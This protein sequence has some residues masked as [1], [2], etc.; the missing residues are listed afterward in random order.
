MLLGMA[1]LEIEEIEGPDG[2]LC[3]CGCEEESHS[4]VV[5]GWQ[6]YF[7]AA[8][9]CKEAVARDFLRTANREE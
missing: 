9:G 1:T 8:P 2:G 6:G 7:D 4:W 3:P 5:K